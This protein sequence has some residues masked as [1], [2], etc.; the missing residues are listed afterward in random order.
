MTAA[1]RQRFAHTVYHI[2]ICIEAAEKNKD[3]AKYVGR[4]DINQLQVVSDTMM[5]I[6]AFS[7]PG[8]KRAVL[9][10]FPHRWQPMLR[11][12]HALLKIRRPGQF[13]VPGAAPEDFFCS[14]H[15]AN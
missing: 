10:D 12:L 2:W 14:S 8:F 13:V 6:Y 5:W 11:R 9:S 4:V 15:R 1:E 3:I 7:S